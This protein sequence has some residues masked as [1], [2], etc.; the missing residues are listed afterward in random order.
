MWVLAGFNQSHFKDVVVKLTAWEHSNCDWLKPTNA[1]PLKLS[2]IRET[3]RKKMFA[4]STWAQFIVF[5]SG[6][7]RQLAVIS[8]GYGSLVYFSWRLS[9]TRYRYRL[10]RYFIAFVQEVS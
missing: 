6:V 1:K 3:T 7:R 10:K 8:C 5:S 9:H 2:L 4:V